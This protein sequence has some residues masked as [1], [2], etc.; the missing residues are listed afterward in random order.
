[1][2][3]SEIGKAD[4]RPKLQAGVRA[5]EIGH[6]RPSVSRLDLA[7]FANRLLQQNR[8]RADIARDEAGLAVKLEERDG[9][10]GKF[11]A[12]MVEEWHR[13]GRLIELEKKWKIP[14]SAYLKTMHEKYKKKT[15]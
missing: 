12:E 2:E 4:T 8:P 9:P 3:Q 15:M 6:P 14:A 5:D 13:S 7:R 10:W 1:V 11:M